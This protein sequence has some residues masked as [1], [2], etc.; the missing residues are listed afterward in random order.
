MPSYIQY[1]IEIDHLNSCLLGC[2]LSR[3]GDEHY[4]AFITEYGLYEWNVACFGLRNAPTE[5]ARF[6]SLTLREFL[7]DFVVVYF[8]TADFVDMPIART[9]NEKLLGLYV[10]RTVTSHGC[11]RKE[12]WDLSRKSYYYHLR[13]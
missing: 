10:D 4:I 8:L 5:F 1:Y 3:E 9:K 13:T 7:N 11:R 12:R 2:A 6:M